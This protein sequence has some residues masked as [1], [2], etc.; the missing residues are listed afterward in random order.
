MTFLSFLV[1]AELT[2]PLGNV[3]EKPDYRESRY[4]GKVTPIARVDI[5]PQVSGEIVAVEFQNGQRVQAGEALYHIDSVKYKAALS[6]AEAKLAECKSNLRY[7]ELNYSRHQ[8]LDE[9]KAV[10]KD[11]IDNALAQKDGAKATYQAALANFTSAQDD[12][13]HCTITAPISGK[14]GTT[15]KTA[16]NYVSAGSSPLVSIVQLDPIRVKFSVSNREILDLMTAEDGARRQKDDV[17]VSITLANGMSLGTDGVIE[18]LD[19]ESDELTDT[20]CLYAKFDNPVRRLVPGGTVAVTVS[21]KT[22][23]MKVAVPPT[24]VLQDTQGP[25]V[26]VVRDD[27]TLERRTIARGHLI[28]DWLFV[29]KGL[30]VGETIVSD[31]AHRVKRGDT[32]KR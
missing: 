22:G 29:E 10:S 13:K 12:L 11:A 20:V 28:G 26:W 6:L 23:V 4:P 30:S 1:A 2:L 15:Q 3:V 8:K 9:A 25:Y 19:N 7:A 18:Y 24:A 32:I 21:S 16:G 14:I 5:V 17:K 27:N 31:G